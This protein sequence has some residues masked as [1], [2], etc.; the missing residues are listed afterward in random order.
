MRYLNELPQKHYQWLCGIKKE[1]FE[2]S[3]SETM[4]LSIIA[5]A[6]AD[7]I[8]DRLALQVYMPLDDIP[9]RSI[10][11]SENIGLRQRGYF[12]AHKYGHQKLGP[13][14]EG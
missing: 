2:S 3:I 1:K 4:K 11:M 9:A 7:N 5:I 12:V 8:V 6:K 13:H 10:P 14:F